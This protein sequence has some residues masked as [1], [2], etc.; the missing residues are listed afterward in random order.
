[1]SGE[2]LVASAVDRSAEPDAAADGRRRVGFWN[3]MAR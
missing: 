2:M 1:V 3:F